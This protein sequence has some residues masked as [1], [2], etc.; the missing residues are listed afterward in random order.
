MRAAVLLASSISVAPKAETAEL[1]TKSVAAADRGGA[2]AERGA[3]GGVVGVVD[4][5]LAE[6]RDRV[7]DDVEFG[8]VGPGLVEGRVAA[9]AAGRVGAGAEVDDLLGHGAGPPL[10]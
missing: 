3:G 8:D 6:G 5:R 1:A 7:G 2:E 4:Q 9:V 10:G